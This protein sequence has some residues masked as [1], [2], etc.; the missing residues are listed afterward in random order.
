MNKEAIEQAAKE[1]AYAILDSGEGVWESIPRRHEIASKFAAIIA[2]HCH[3]TA[4]EARAELTEKDAEIEKWRMAAELTAHDVAFFSGNT[5]LEPD[6]RN[7]FC[8]L[9]NDCFWW[10]SADAERVLLDQAP[11][12]YRIYQIGG[13][14]ALIE[15]IANKRGMRPMPEL[16]A[17]MQERK[18]SREIALAEGRERVRTAIVQRVREIVV[19]DEDCWTQSHPHDV[20]DCPAKVLINTA[21]E[22]E[23]MS[24]EEGKD[25]K[26]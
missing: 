3:S 25:A 22:I 10:A 17:D 13:E 1:A 2:K 16:E 24:L 12:M 26:V 15:W 8:L 9:C 5:D 7:R 18:S 6:I 11:E 21:A 20:C 14:D 19:H 23:T 4:P